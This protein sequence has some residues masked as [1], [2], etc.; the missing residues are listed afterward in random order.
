[1]LQEANIEIEVLP[2]DKFVPHTTKLVK[3][4]EEGIAYLAMP[5]WQDHVEIRGVVAALAE[6]VAGQMGIP[7]PSNFQAAAE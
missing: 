7:Q 6:Y 1:M 4:P 3:N 5:Q 2:T